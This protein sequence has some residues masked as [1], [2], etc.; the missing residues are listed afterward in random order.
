MFSLRRF[1]PPFLSQMAL[2]KDDEECKAKVMRKF[3][4]ST[5]AIAFSRLFGFTDFMTS[6]VEIGRV[7]LANVYFTGWI[8]DEQRIL[9]VNGSPPLMDVDGCGIPYSLMVL[10]QSLEPDG[11]ETDCLENIDITK[12]PLYR[13][14]ANRVANETAAG[15]FPPMIWGG[16]AMFETMQYVGFGGQR[17]TVRFDLLGCHACTLA[18]Y[19]H[20]A[21]DFD[22]SGKFLGTKLLRLS[23]PIRHQK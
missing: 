7:S 21:Y 6:F 20:V 4:A 12:H 8:N 23:R 10:R 1:D 14:L 19:A 15:A 5:E 9:L 13:S 17:F 18:G 11:K 16:H 3:G 2:C 22:S